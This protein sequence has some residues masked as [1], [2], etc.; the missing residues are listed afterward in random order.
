MSGTPRRRGGGCRLFDEVKQ[1][2]GAA[3]TEGGHRHDCR[4][5]DHQCACFDQERREGARSRDASDEKGQSVDFSMKAHVGVD[6]RTKL[7]HAA[8]VTPANVADS[9]VVPELLH[10]QETRVWGDQ[11]Y[12]GHRQS[13]GSTPQRQGTSPITATAIAESWTRANGRKSAPSRRCAS[14]L[15]SRSGSSKRVFGFV[16]VRYRCS[17]RVGIYCAANRC[18][19]AALVQR[20]VNTS[21]GASTGNGCSPST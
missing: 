11:A 4:C 7:I 12:R 18:N 19:V 10:G 21:G 13:S 20:G 1:H 2:P 6:S 9:A 3:R 5:D 16:K 8:V 14:R 15:G 17:W